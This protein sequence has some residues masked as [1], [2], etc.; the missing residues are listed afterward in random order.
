[1]GS[2]AALIA[3]LVTELEQANE[4]DRE[5]SDVVLRALGWKWE[6]RHYE[7]DGV[8]L[9]REVILKPDGNI[10]DWK[11][12]PRPDP[13]RNLQC[14]VDLVPEGWRVYS[15][16][17]NHHGDL[18]WYA[19]IDEV[20]KSGNVNS[21]VINGGPALALVIAILKAVEAKDG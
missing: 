19:G 3:E 16:Q 12:R 18:R 7:M 9:S 21:G 11:T 5:L 8:K 4:G 20:Y 14:A 13:T 6:T 10:W 2:H 1:M 15:I 17:Q